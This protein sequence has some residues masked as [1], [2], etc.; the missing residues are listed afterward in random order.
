MDLLQLCGY[1]IDHLAAGE[2]ITKACIY[3]TIVNTKER[4]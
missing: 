1:D 3:I 2:K 4:R